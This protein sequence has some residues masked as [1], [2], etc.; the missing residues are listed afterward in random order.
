MRRSDIGS[1]GPQWA[2]GLLPFL[3]VEQVYRVILLKPI[4]AR[5]PEVQKG[6]EMPVAFL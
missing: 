1:F 5:S 2:L 4:I 3:F 6:S